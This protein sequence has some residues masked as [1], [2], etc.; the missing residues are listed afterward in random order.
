MCRVHME[1]GGQRFNSVNGTHRSPVKDS[2]ETLEG[3]IFIRMTD[4]HVWY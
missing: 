3:L 2:V 1:G 4:P